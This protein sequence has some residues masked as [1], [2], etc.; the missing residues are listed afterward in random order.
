MLPLI[1]YLGPNHYKFSKL[2]G[3]HTKIT[4]NLG[5]CSK[6]SHLCVILYHFIHLKHINWNT[7]HFTLS[8]RDTTL[9]RSV[10]HK[11]TELERE[12]KRE[13]TS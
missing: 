5:G 2:N 4:C 3:I 1:N 8:C 9:K 11:T 10:F 12:K 13:K 7:V 6:N